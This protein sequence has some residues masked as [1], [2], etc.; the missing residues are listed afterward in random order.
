[1]RSGSADLEVC[2][3]SGSG[4]TTGGSSGIP[5][6]SPACIDLSTEIWECGRPAVDADPAD[7]DGGDADRA[8]GPWMN[9][10]APRDD[11]ILMPRPLDA[12]GLLGK[13]MHGSCRAGAL[14]GGHRAW[15]RCA[16]WRGTPR[17]ACGNRSI[18]LRARR[19]RRR[20]RQSIF[21]PV[22]F[23]LSRPC[24]YSSSGSHAPKCGFVRT[25]PSRA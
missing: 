11:A 19:S 7:A 25:A 8:P 10:S 4:A 24:E 6:L 13:E 15:R 16:A 12:T 5:T 18:R 3:S 22:A 1:L 2:A 23:P 20:A 9:E 17:N 14:R 21:A